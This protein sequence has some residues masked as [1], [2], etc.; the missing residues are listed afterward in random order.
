MSQ[1]LITHKMSRS[2]IN[3]KYNS[4]SST[5]R[6]LLEH[7]DELQRKSTEVA[8][9]CQQQLTET[10]E[11]GIVTLDEIRNQNQT[12]TQIQAA[13][14]MTNAKL[15]HTNKLLNRYDRWAFHWYGGDKRQARR[16]GKQATKEGKLLEKQKQREF[17]SKADS[18]KT[19]IDHY[20]NHELNR[21][22]L[23]PNSKNSRIRTIDTIPIEVDG[24]TVASP[25]DKETK[26][27]LLKIEDQDEALDNMLSDMVES[28]DRLSHISK[29]MNVD[30]SQGN[31]Q[32]NQ[33]IKNVDQVNHKQFV[34]Q[35]RL[36]RN[37]NK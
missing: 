29:T 1:F 12:M 34:A 31:Q 9:R 6:L 28:L 2:E 35:G 24:D 22:Q 19:P 8:Q 20:G 7:A 13:A 23:I 18:K 16:E 21:S 36:R 15:D 3:R 17:P 37:L 10:E 26:E 33:V 25:L 5:N 11:L 27:Y 4:S 14:D 32:L 30:I